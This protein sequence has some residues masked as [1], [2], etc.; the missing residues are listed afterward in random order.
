MAN[1]KYRNKANKIVPSV[2]TIIGSNLGWNTR[3]LMAWQAR[4]FRDGK[5]PDLVKDDAAIL[6]TLVHDFVEAEIYGTS[7]DTE[8]LKEHSMQH[9]AI[10]ERGVEQ[11]RQICSE[12]AVKWLETELPLVSETY[13]YGGRLDGLCTLDGLPMVNLADVKTSK[14]IYAEFII[15]LAGYDNLL[16]ECTE[17]R[18]EGY[19]FFHISKDLSLDTENI[20]TIKS[21]PKEA[22]D[23][24]W[25]IFK[26]LLI[27]HE[28][29]KYFRKLLK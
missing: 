26:Q 7:I 28:Y 8:T 27:Q 20:I 12:R 23:K 10:A 13:Q 18:P 11:F 29:N 15:Q 16:L 9:I 6:G 19:L 21:V 25:D 3:T 5:D 17:Y 4:M 1:D 22:I 14:A 24:G 2:T